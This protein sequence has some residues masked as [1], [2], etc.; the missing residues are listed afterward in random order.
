M[1]DEHSIRPTRFNH[2]MPLARRSGRAPS[3]KLTERHIHVLIETDAFFLG[4]L[5]QVA[6]EDFGLAANVV[7]QLA[8]LA[9]HGQIGVD[10]GQLFA[11]E[12][13]ADAQR[14]QQLAVALVALGAQPGALRAPLEVLLARAAAFAPAQ[15]Q[16]LIGRQALPA[17]VAGVTKHGVLDG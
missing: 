4:A 16:R 12:A 15:A 8:V 11:D 2:N 6:I 5:R 7:E 13:R 9:Q 10:V 17:D 1:S 3:H 14:V